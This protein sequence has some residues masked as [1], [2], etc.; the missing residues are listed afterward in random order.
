MAQQVTDPTL[1]QAV[2]KCGGEADFSNVS[3]PSVKSMSKCDM[4]P[5][6]GAASVKIGHDP[7]EVLERY[8]TRAS[9]DHTEILTPGTEQAVEVRSNVDERQLA[10]LGVYVSVDGDGVECSFGR[11]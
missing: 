9:G 8:H 4:G 10:N 6:S 3:L 7:S 2:P 1:G 11:Q 5:S